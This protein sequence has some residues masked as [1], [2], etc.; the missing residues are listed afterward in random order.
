[1][2][3]S[4]WI[5]S[6]PT[7][8]LRLSLK[9][10][11]GGTPVSAIFSLACWARPVHQP[12]TLT[13]LHASTELSP[14]PMHLSLPPSPGPTCQGLPSLPCVTPVASPGRVLEP[15]ALLQTPST[16]ACSSHALC[17]CPLNAAQR[18]HFKFLPCDL[19]S[20][21]E[22]MFRVI[23]FHWCHLNHSSDRSPPPSPEFGRI[24]VVI[25][26]PR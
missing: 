9:L 11:Y 8:N 21:R 15:C 25:Q 22:Y 18:H 17:P 14:R 4:V 13:A 5:K 24:V 7:H 23:V 16:A 12:P 6:K 19:L 10:K 20:T 26:F 2:E 1:L 3:G